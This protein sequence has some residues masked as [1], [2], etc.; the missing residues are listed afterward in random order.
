MTT[1]EFWWW[2]L[3]VAPKCHIMHKLVWELVSVNPFIW[4]TSIL[5][6]TLSDPL[7]LYGSVC[8]TSLVNSFD[9]AFNTKPV[10][11]RILVCV[12]VCGGKEETTLHRS[13]LPDRCTPLLVICWWL[14]A[15]ADQTAHDSFL[16]NNTVYSNHSLGY[17]IMNLVPSEIVYV[18]LAS[19]QLR[20][21][22]H[23]VL[24]DVS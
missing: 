9:F 2:L 13:L 6:S 22:T 19:E 21:F 24:T 3:H 14:D 5:Y 18:H 17:W 8:V 12:C 10:C 1:A 15:E 16:Q 23:C 4:F 7:V 20:T 11:I